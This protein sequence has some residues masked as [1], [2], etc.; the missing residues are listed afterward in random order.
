MRYSKQRDALLKLLRST[1]SHPDAE[2]LYTTLK[3]EYPNISLGT[4]YRNLRQL[5]ENGD[6]LE[7]QCGG[8]S[9]FD[10]TVSMHYHLKC[11]KCGK[12]LDIEKESVNVMLKPN[13][14]YDV[15]DFSLMLKGVCCNCKKSVN[16]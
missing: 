11:N 13:N 15:E 4:V 5:S 12:I 8:I 9:H 7:F 6:I 14:L 3:G 16:A 1:T 10:A 2:W